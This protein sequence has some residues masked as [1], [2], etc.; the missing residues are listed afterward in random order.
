MRIRAGFRLGYTCPKPT[1][2]LLSLEIHPSRRNDL[3]SE[4]VIRFE[5][6]LDAWEH[7]PVGHATAE[8]AS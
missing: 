2:M 4:Q 7:I 5:P 3:L 6:D 1:P 8:L